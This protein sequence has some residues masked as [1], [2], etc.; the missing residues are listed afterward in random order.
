VNRATLLITGSIDLKQVQTPSTVIRDTGKR[1][2]QYLDAIEY[3][4]DH[5]TEVE[6]IIFCENTNFDFNYTPLREKAEKKVR[7]SKF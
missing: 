2:K 4:I 1:L 3:A 5:Y 7:I 6:T